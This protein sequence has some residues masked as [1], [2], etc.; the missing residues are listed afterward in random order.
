MFKIS[1]NTNNVVLI[2]GANSFLGK[3]VVENLSNKFTVLKTGTKNLKD[4]NYFQANL[5]IKDEAK[6]LIEWALEKEKK[7]DF[8]ICCA[9]GNKIFPKIDDS[10][11]INS[12]DITRLFELNVITAINCCH[13]ILPHMIKRNFGRICF[14]GSDLVGKPQENGFLTGY[15]I[16]KAALHEYTSH[17]ANQLKNTGV[18]VNCVSPCG[19][20][21]SSNDGKTT[22][23][24]SDEVSKK[25]EFFYNSKLN[26]KV[27]RVTK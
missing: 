6:K 3:T 5:T 18:L 2:T 17:L 8:L 26:G 9:G 12:K 27:I 25:I 10:Y 1:K 13:F 24:T 14:V 19:I 4:L 16:S 23:V 20:A 22:D 15:S 7:I 11:N 21:G